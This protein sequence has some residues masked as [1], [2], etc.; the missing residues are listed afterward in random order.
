MITEKVRQNHRL[1]WHPVRIFLQTSS[2][3]L[4]HIFS[5]L[6]NQLYSDKILAVVREYCT[7]A[8]DANIDAGVPDCPIQVSI[9]N[10]FSPFFK[11]R[12]FGKGLSEEQVY[13]I[14]GSYGNPP[15]ATPMSRL[16]AWVLVP[17]LHSLMSIHSHSRHFT[18]VLR[19]F[20]RHTLMRLK[21]GKITRLSV[22]PSARTIRH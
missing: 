22:E 11:V 9:P 7:N 18:L 10:A 21:I 5:I 1:S 2:K 3:N 20:T 16:D 8:M 12:D 4:A 14:F 15:S 13:N 17:S 19:Q 6:R